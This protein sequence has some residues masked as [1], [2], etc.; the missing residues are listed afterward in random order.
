MGIKV[1]A[2][3][4]GFYGQY[5]EVNDEFEVANE[6]AFH[7]SWMDRADSKAQK[8]KVAQINATGN[9]PAGAKPSTQANELPDPAD[10]S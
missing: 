10:L 7:D 8:R 3:R 4:P 5:R 6:E 1:I 9:N 2:H